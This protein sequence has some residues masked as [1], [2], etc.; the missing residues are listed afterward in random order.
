MG[1]DRSLAG[2]KSRFLGD[3]S[4]LTA[5]ATAESLGVSVDT[6]EHGRPSIKAWLHTQLSGLGSLG[7]PGD[8]HER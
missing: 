7:E 6:I 3:F 5:Q 2:F 4:G 8:G 1:V